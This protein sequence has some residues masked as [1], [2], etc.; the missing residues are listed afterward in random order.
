MVAFDAGKLESLFFDDPTSFWSTTF[1]T[2][3]SGAP[4]LEDLMALLEVV[5]V[6][7]ERASTDWRFFWNLK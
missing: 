5:A 3:E 1:D 2:G 7:V 4:F 6:A